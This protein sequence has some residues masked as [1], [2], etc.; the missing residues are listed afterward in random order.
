MTKDLLYQFYLNTNSGSPPIPQSS[1]FS[2]PSV[3]IT[4]Y[5]DD[6]NLTNRLFYILPLLDTSSIFV[7]YEDNAFRKDANGDLSL[8]HSSLHIW[9]P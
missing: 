2:F 3:N 7:F 1:L 8:V 6:H 5:E 9:H 4:I